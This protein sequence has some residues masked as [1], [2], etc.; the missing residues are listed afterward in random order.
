MKGTT[1]KSELKRI[2]DSMDCLTDKRYVGRTFYGV[3]DKDLRFKAAFD[4]HDNRDREHFALNTEIIRRDGG[5]VDTNSIRFVDVWGY[6]ESTTQFYREGLPP[7][8]LQE[9]NKLEWYDYKPTEADMKLL[10]KE[11]SEMVDVYKS[12]S[13]TEEISADVTETDRKSELLINCINYIKF[14]NDS[15][16]EHLHDVCGFTDKELSEL[17]F[18]Y[19]MQSEVEDDEEMDM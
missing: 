16:I 17:G 19:L 4:N 10:S 9:T 13:L 3:I 7:H 2:F 5:I 12:Q 8:L 6:K 15:T 14:D 1:F 18:D 11:I